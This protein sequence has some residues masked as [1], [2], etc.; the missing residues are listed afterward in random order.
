VKPVNSHLRNT[1]LAGAFAAVPVAVTVFVIW[2]INSRTTPISHAIFG[3][4]I[5]FLGIIVS[6]LAIY[7]LGLVV[8][9]FFGHYVLGL[10][11]SLLSRMPVVKPIYEAWK[12]ISLIPGGR[13]GVY[14]RV[15]L[16][17]LTPGGVHMLAFTS[18]EPVAG[19]KDICCVLVPNAP[20]PIT[21]RLYFV[22]KH[23][24]RFVDL[25]PEEALKTLVSNGNYVPAA[26]GQ[27]LSEAAE[28]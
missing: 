2:W 12:H 14:S 7:A 8:T 11:D 10:L 13:E 15:V 1:F 18:G 22:H 24:L 28:N 25:S 23:L 5:P 19:S 4:D 6:L 3:H 21:G 17:P 20:N 26:I 27:A 9:S 16:V